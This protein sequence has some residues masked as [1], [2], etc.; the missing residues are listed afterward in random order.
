MRAVSYTFALSAYTLVIS[1][2]TITSRACATGSCGLKRRRT[3][4]LLRLSPSEAYY[5]RNKP[6]EASPTSFQTTTSV[7][8][9]EQDA[10]A[11]VIVYGDITGDY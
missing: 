1:P 6:E 8:W 11:L 3:P 4:G 9:L 7:A 5:S 2:Y 10:E